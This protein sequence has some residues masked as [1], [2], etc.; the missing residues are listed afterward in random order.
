MKGVILAGGHGTRLQPLTYITNKHLL[1]V[2]DKPMIEYPLKTL[3]DLGCTDILIITGGKHLGSFA[4]YLGDGRRSGVS[5]TYRVQ[6]MAGGVAHALLEAEGYV[7]GLFPVILGD[8]YFESRPFMPPEP[9]IFYKEVD[10]ASRFGV[11]NP[12]LNNIVEKPS[13]YRGLAV[14][15]FYVYD[16]RVFNH[17]RTLSPSRRK[18]LEITDVNNWYLDQGATAYEYKPFWSD[19]GA[20]DT[21]YEVSARLKKETVHESTG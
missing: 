12:D 4:E 15:G 13:V 11:Y 6:E 20:F 10:N 3:V 14:V 9:A 5:I 21:L 19:M 16:D 8:N 18:E 7:D 1:P 17:I 2:Y